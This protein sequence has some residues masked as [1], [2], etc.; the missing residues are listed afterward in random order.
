MTWKLE[1]I[2]LPQTLLIAKIISSY[3]ERKEEMQ[4]QA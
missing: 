4:L 1:G 3:T 2:Y